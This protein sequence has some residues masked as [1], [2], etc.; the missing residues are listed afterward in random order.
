MQSVIFPEQAHQAGIIL[1]RPVSCRIS[2]AQLVQI[3]L[4][5]PSPRRCEPL[6]EAFTVP[7]L[8]FP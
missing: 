6:Y 4:Y 2:D 8:I 1:L 5:S 7:M 3:P